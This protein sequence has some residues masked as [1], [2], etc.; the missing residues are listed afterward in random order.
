MIRKLI[1]KFK[2]VFVDGRTVIAPGY[3]KNI[4]AADYYKK[5]ET[6]PNAYKG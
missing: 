3:G 1:R 4:R 5:V 6:F 2:E